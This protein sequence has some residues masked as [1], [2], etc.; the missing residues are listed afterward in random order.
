MKS[1]ATKMC[2]SSS[3]YRVI[4]PR[5]KPFKIAILH[6]NDNLAFCNNCELRPPFSDHGLIR[7][8]RVGKFLTSVSPRGR[9]SSS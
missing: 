5:T 2:T 1:E 7:S 8:Y 9:D 4:T 3:L 6:F